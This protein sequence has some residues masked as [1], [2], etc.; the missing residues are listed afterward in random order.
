MIASTN[1][2]RNALITRRTTNSGWLLAIDC[3]WK[4]NTYFE[5]KKGY[6]P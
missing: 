6:F 5:S 3:Y 2:A 4:T 1:E